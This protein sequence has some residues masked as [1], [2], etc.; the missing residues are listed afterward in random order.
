MSLDV[1]LESE[2]PVRRAGGAKIFVREGGQTKEI[3]REEWD[4]LHPDREPVVVFKEEHDSSEVFHGNITHN[5]NR[6]AE[7]AG[8]YEVLWKPEE[9]D[10]ACAE[11]LIRPLEGGLERLLADPERYRQLDPPN[12]WGSYDVLVDFVRGYLAACREHPS[13]KVRVW[14]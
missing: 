3:S 6:M 9:V 5:L 2:V 12:G 4:H 10:I 14:R 7:A 13:A 11:G 1:Y 8:L